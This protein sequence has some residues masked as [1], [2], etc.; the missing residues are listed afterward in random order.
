MPDQAVVADLLRQRVRESI[1]DRR[2]HR[3]PLDETRRFQR[4]D[5]R[6]EVDVRRHHLGEECVIELPP[7]HRRDPHDLE[8]VASRLSSRARIT[9]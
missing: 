7:D 3:G 6:A 9:P 1:A 5:R 8:R 2:R 4:A